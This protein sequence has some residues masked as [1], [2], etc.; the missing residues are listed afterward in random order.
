MRPVPVFCIQSRSARAKP[1]RAPGH[2]LWY[3]WKVVIL[4]LGL[5]VLPKLVHFFV[6]CCFRRGSAC[7]PSVL[8]LPV[9]L[10]V[11]V[12]R[13]AFVLLLHPPHKQSLDSFTI[14]R[15]FVLAVPPSNFC[16]RGV[17]LRFFLVLSFCFVGF[18]SLHR[19]ASRLRLQSLL[20]LG[21]AAGF[22]AD[23][24]HGVGSTLLANECRTDALGGCPK[25]T[26]HSRLVTS[27]VLADSHRQVNRAR[28][29]EQ[30]SSLHTRTQWY[31]F[32]PLFF[33]PVYVSSLRGRSRFLWAT[34]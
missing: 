6:A 11:C 10:A 14:A 20:E 34:Y 23:R 26:D 24:K 3:T 18:A 13:V 31:D 33:I 29:R 7:F 15:R 1:L 19:F 16:G 28:N 17:L 21:V 30:I 8:S 25:M 9:W 4:L 5:G 22:L 27:N 2:C 32:D 12:R